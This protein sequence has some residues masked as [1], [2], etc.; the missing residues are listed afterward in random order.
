MKRFVVTTVLAALTIGWSAAAYAQPYYRYS[1]C[2]NNNSKACRDA[3]DAFA[4]HH[5]GQYPEQWYGHWYQGQQGRWNQVD[6]NWRWEG[7][8]G[9]EY[10]NGP[11][12]WEWKHHDHD[13]DHDH[14]H[15]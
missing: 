1:T 6:N 11:K 12:G 2:V 15:H 7:M 3:R 8:D 5:N 9:D 10:G 13:H 14:D 4:G